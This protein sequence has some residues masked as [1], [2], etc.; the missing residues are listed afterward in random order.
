M[1]VLRSRGRSVS[2]A[3]EI[4][5]SCESLA[6]TIGV[7]SPPVFASVEIKSPCLFGVLRPA[8]LLPSDMSFVS[9]DVLVHE[10]AHLRHMNHSA[11]FWNFVSQFDPD[12]KQHRKE[13]KSYS[14]R[15]EIKTVD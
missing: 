3:P 5:R 2:A 8:I 11:D 4:A 7:R 13:L 10:L 1:M 9:R 12:Y 15:A 6:K 14:L